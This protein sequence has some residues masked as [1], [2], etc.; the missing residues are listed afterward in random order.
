MYVRTHFPV[1]PDPQNPLKCPKIRIF[2]LKNRDQASKRGLLCPK[3]APV[4]PETYTTPFDIGI[5][6]LSKNLGV[7]RP[8]EP[9]TV[10][11]FLRGGADS[12]PPLTCRVKITVKCILDFVMMICEN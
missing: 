5:E 11:I 7:S 1:Q 8:I 4:G 12:A 9:C 2:V 6:E 10:S 3:E